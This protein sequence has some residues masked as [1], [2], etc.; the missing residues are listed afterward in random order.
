MN[1]SSL[2]TNLAALLSTLNRTDGAPESSVYLVLGCD[3]NEWLTIRNAAIALGWLSCRGSWVSLTPTG[4][5]KAEQIDA[6][7]GR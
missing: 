7:A 1:A 4:E 6:I 5:A 2:I 3:W